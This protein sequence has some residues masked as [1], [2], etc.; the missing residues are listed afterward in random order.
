MSLPGPS[1]RLVFRQYRE[2]DVDDVALMFSDAQALR[3]Y[4]EMTDGASRRR[5]IE[6]NLE[7]YERDG[8]GLWVIESRETGEF[9]GDC[10]LTYQPVEGEMLLELGYHLVAR[11]RGHGLA[12]EA[13]R[14]CLEHAFGVLSEDWVCSTVHPDNEASIAVASRLHDHRRT[15]EKPD[16]GVRLLFWSERG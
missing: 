13:G 9:L 4:P 16:G 7:N 1:D 12:T 6:W 2:T 15:Y 3:F 14:A 10:G 8:F 5:W 11:H